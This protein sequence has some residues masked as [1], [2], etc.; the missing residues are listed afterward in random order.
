MA[1]V[2]VNGHE[3]GTLWKPAYTVAIGHVIQ[4]GENTLEVEVVN[5]WLNRLVGDAQPG[6]EH[7]ETFTT[8]TLWNAGTPLQSAGLLGPVVLRAAK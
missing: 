6:V 7:P 3:V 2:R 5:T 8:T 1:R 4:P